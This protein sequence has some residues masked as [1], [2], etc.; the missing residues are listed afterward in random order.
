[1]DR[2]DHDTDTT[3][4]VEHHERERIVERPR[5]TPYVAPAASNVNVGPT[6]T[7]AAAANNAVL[8]VTRI[9]TLILTVLEILLLLRFSLKLLGANA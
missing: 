7:A 9:V 2:R 6:T 3:Q 5:A 8:V 1:M 4:R